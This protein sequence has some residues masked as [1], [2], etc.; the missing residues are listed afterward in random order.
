L[1]KERGSLELIITYINSNNLRGVLKIDFIMTSLL[2]SL[3]R[4]REPNDNF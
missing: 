2:P 1:K 4:E 3:P